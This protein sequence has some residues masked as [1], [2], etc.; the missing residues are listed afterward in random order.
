VPDGDGGF[1]Q[2]WTDL[3]LKLD[4]RVAPASQAALERVAAGTVLTN[5]THVVTIPYLDGVST[6]SRILLDGRVLNITSVQDPDERH[7]ELMLVCQEA[8]NG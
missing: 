5:A 3:V 2:A 4:A 6:S 7:V 1:T 8:V